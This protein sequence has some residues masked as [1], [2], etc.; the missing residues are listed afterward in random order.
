MFFK[1]VF[2][3]RH[4]IERWCERVS[5]YSDEDHQQVITAFQSSRKCEDN[6]FIPGGK[7]RNTTYYYSKEHDCY[8]VIDPLRF[9]GAAQIVTVIRNDRIVL[10]PSTEVAERKIVNIASLP[11]EEKIQVVIGWMEEREELKRE[12]KKS[13]ESGHDYHLKGHQEIIQKRL[14][15]INEEDAESN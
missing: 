5:V 6:E 2:V 13:Q 14:Q 9:P 8:F 3:S 11:D 12:Y 15:A 1:Q 7:L 10:V 4:A